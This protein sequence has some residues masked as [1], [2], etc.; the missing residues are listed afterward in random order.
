[1]VCLCDTFTWYRCSLVDVD[2]KYHI[3]LKDALV[4][5]VLITIRAITCRAAALEA[6]A[7]LCD[8]VLSLHFELCF[9]E[10]LEF[11]YLKLSQS[12]ERKI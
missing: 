11:D 6:A 9:V 12:I 8:D 3:Q 5:S 10:F 2:F 7:R 4:L 1:M